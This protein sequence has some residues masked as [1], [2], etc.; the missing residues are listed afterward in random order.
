MNLYIYVCESVS[1]LFWIRVFCILFLFSFWF[2]R[3]LLIYA[4]NIHF[5][6]SLKRRLDT[7][8]D[9]FKFTKRLKIQTK[10]FE[11]KIAQLKEKLLNIQQE[12]DTLKAQLERA[13]SGEKNLNVNSV[14]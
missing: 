2:N 8:I 1:V 9:S 7:E 14:S 10:N 6:N 3:N 4:W 11:Q 13:L 12:N 5:S